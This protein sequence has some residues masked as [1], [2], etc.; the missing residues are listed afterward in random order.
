EIVQ[1]PFDKIFNYGENKTYPPLDKIITASE[2]INGFLIAIT[3]H[4]YQEGLLYSTTG[5]LSGTHVDM[6]KQMSQP[7]YGSLI[8]YLLDK[9][10]TLLF[11]VIHPDD[12]HPIPSEDYGIYLIGCREK[13][14]GYCFTEEE[15]DELGN[16]LEIPRPKHFQ[17]P[18]AEVL[19]ISNKVEIEGYV[20]RDQ[21]QYLCKIKTPYYLTIKFL[22]RLSNKRIKHLFHSPE[23]FKKECEEEFYQVVDLITQ[24]WTLEDYLSL[25]EIDKR[26]WL[27]KKL[28]RSV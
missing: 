22:S 28:S 15:L 18:L 9:N 3:K 5:S 10:Q 25:S 6:G 12:P 27:I 1:R 16:K 17:S 14:S 8:K 11:E 20:I 26:D 19:N 4:P 24:H 2:K 21:N 13:I 23:S 7:H